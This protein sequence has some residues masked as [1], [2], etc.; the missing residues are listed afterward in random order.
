MRVRARVRAARGGVEKEV[1]SRARANERGERERELKRGRTN[2]RGIT[3]ER[4]LKI[5]DR[6]R[7]AQN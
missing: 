7:V 6:G 5:E 4:E 2:E 3:D 1:D